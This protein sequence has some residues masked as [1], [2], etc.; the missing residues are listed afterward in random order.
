MPSNLPDLNGR[1]FYPAR[2][3]KVQAGGVK[4]M[5]YWLVRVEMGFYSTS[6]GYDANHLRWAACSRLLFL[7]VASWQT[8]EVQAK[9]IWEP[10]PKTTKLDAQQSL[11]M[12][13][14]MKKALGWQ[15]FSGI[16]QDL[17]PPPPPPTPLPP[18]KVK[19][20]K[21]RVDGAIN[22]PKAENFTIF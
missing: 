8:K 11:W 15:P 6:L 5:E 4:L 10:G 16:L 12:Q 9:L 3:I 22:G 20:L 17:I 14:N 21:G 18:H 2:L 7:D 13:V 19:A 1:K